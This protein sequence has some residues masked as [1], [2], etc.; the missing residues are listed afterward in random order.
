MNRVLLAKVR[1]R[2]AE[3]G[4]EHCN[5][6]E[7]A[8]GTVQAQGEPACGTTACIA[9]WTLAVHRGAYDGADLEG[10]QGVEVLLDVPS[11]EL[12]FKSSWPSH[13]GRIADDEG[14]AKGMLAVCDALLDGALTFNDRGELVECDFLNAPVVTTQT[15]DEK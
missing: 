15:G 5:M 4:N 14:D 8:Q 13:Y 3:V 6:H 11:D 12:F 7:W 1:D 9:G 2:I 10:L